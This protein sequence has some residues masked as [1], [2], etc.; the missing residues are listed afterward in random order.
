[1]TAFVDP[2]ALDAFGPNALARLDA[3]VAADLAATAHP[4]ACW[5]EPRTGPD[6]KPAL[7]VLVVGGGQSG[8][9]IAFCLRRSQVTNIL[10][11][12]KAARGREGPWLTYARMKTLR[13]PK[14]YTGPDLDIPSLTYQAWHE[15]NFGAADWAALPLIPKEHWARYLL[16]FRDVLALPVRN[17]TELLDIAPAAGGL[18]AATM[19]SDD[20]TVQTAFTRKIV[21]A[22]GQE[23]AGRWS[24]PAVLDG[25]PHDRCARACD[26]IDFAALRGKEV[27]VVGAGASA[28]DNAAT[29]LEAGAA[30]VHLLCRRARPQVVQPYR[31]LTF[32]GFLRHLADLDDVWRW[33]FMRTIMTLREGFTQPTFDRCRRHAA[34]A[35]HVASPVTEARTLGARVRLTTVRQTLDVDFVIAATGIEIDFAR[36]P[37]LARFAGNIAMWGDRYTPPPDEADP[38]LARYPYLDAD[39]AFAEREAGRTPWIR[40]VHLFAIGSTLSFGASGS[41]INAM[42][43]AIPKLVAGLTKGLFAADVE[44]HWRDLVAYDVAQVDLPA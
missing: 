3:R 35:L 42:T 11:V 5:L 7:D 38:A 27:A 20:G 34:F 10:V 8:L 14:S 31:W 23:G 18:L 28:F 17:G 4:D 19:R 30:R 1:M 22:T 26:P 44:R 9:S 21:L 32:R 39:Y 40:D 37:E 41:S 12:D 16:W 15:A 29:A 36:R 25:L 43:T 13:S 6:G 2:A 24:V 33:R